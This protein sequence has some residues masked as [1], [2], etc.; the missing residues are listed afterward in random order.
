MASLWVLLRLLGKGL[1]GLL[2]V[3]GSRQGACGHVSPPRVGSSCPVVSIVTIEPHVN[4]AESF[5]GALASANVLVV[6][7]SRWLDLPF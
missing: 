2:L 7:F 4:M 1:R 6:C 3:P 5:A